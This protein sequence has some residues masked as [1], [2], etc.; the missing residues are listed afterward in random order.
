VFVIFIPPLRSRRPT[1][2]RKSSIHLIIDY[3]H[4]DVS[5]I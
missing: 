5:S 1:A 3:R 4:N 2:P